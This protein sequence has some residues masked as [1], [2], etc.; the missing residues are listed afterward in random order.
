MSVLS[1]VFLTGNVKAYFK[2][3]KAHAA[4]WNETEARADF[5]KVITLEPSLETSVAKELRAMEERIREKQKEEKGRYKN[6]FNY[7]DKASAAATTVSFISNAVYEE[8][9]LGCIILLNSKK[10][11][12]KAAP[13][14][15]LCYFPLFRAETKMNVQFSIYKEICTV[16]F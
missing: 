15:N 8:S 9:K 1:L 11:K 16:K 13:L 10:K 12:K 4:V 3:G 14:S 5:A 6:L 7:N 2:R